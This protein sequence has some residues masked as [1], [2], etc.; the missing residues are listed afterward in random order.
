[1]KTLKAKKRDPKESTEYIR[2]E[3]K[4]VPAVVYGKG[5]EENILVKVPDNV[6]RSIYRDIRNGSPFT[7]EIEGGDTYTVVLKD[8]QVHPTTGFI[9]HI[10]FMGVDESENA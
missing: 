7:L 5:I 10:D 2:T 4:Y 6:F 3:E 8:M 1:M 9:L